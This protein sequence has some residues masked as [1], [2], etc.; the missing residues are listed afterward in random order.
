MKYSAVPSIVISSF[1]GTCVWPGKRTLWLG[2]HQEND[3]FL[4]ALICLRSV[5][6][7]SGTLYLP[8]NPQIV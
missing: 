7:L 8:W 4:K 6:I 3:K 2:M 5:L 1:G